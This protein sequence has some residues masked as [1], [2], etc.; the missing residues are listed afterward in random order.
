MDAPIRYAKS[1]EVNI[2][3]Q[4]TGSGPFDLVLVSGFVSHLDNDWDH[5]ASAQLLDRLGA[6]A[7]LIRFDKRGTGLSDRTVG[8]PDL[9]TRMDDVRAVM[10][11][12]AS[13]T[14]ALFGYSE[15]GPMSMLFAAAYPQ[16]VRALVLYGTYAKR[17]HPDDEYPWCETWEERERYAEA[18]EREWGVEADMSRMAPGADESVR[19]WWMAR[20]RASASPAA[21]RAL[22]LMNSQ[23]DVRDV[24]ASIQ[25]K[26]L[27]LHRREDPDARL[28][29]GRY[30]AEHIP[31]ARFVELPGETHVP[32]WDSDDLV[33]EI[34]E[35][36][37]GVRPTRLE[38]RVLATT[39]FTDIVD[40]TLKA[41]ELGDRAWA[42]LLSRHHELVRKDIQRYAGEE[43]DTAG[44]GFFALFDGPA[45]AIRCAIGARDA[46]RSLG[47]EIRAG[48]HTGEVERTPGGSP[49]GIAVHIG[50]RVAAQ[51]QGGE[52]LVTSTT[53]DLVAGSGLE[54]SDRGEVELKG[55]GTRRLYAAHL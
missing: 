36:L 40:S 28:E 2:A 11:A 7:R 34:E 9:E 54:F 16:R 46:V 49:G 13:D 4:I 1:G 26:T 18:V 12:A 8:L 5:P 10:D 23:I 37:T 25:A 31:G 21:A 24:L 52:I 3:Y 6:F 20:A 22:V 29:E 41:N 45:R 48:V 30:V 19:R 50:A 44:D 15:G 47:L 55:V 27:V 39:L 42:E 53:S 38:N 32:W 17:T 33:D 43:I 51:A 14:A 35:F